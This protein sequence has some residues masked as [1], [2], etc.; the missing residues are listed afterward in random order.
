MR[1]AAV[2]WA[3]TELAL[4]GELFGGCANAIARS[5]HMTPPQITHY[6]TFSL[7]ETGSKQQADNALS[8]IIADTHPF[9][10]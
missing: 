1:M 9:L 6:V 2:I 10:D 5:V 4:R 8:L 3:V 7:H